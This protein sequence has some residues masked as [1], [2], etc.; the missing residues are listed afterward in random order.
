MPRGN[1]LLATIEAVHAAGL[2]AER[3]PG[4]LEA[5]THL[6]GGI[7]AT[8]E[9]FDRRAPALIEFHSYG[10]PP[11]NELAYLDH[12][13]AL[14]PRIPALINGKPGGLVTDYTVLD[15]R[16]MNGNPFYADFLMPVGYRYFIG[17]ILTVTNQFSSLFSVQRATR[18]GHVDRTEMMHM[19]CLLPHVRQAFDVTRRLRRASEAHGVF[20][21]ALD[22]LADGVALVRAD[23]AIVYANEALRAI[24]R[25][26]DGLRITK[27]TFEFAAPESRARFNAALTAIATLRANGALHDEATDLAVTRGS[28]LPP[29]LI[30]VRPLMGAPRNRGTDNR[31]VAIIFVRDPLSRNPAATQVLR[32]V[33]GL[34]EAEANLARALQ[35][36]TPIAAYVREHAV[37]INTV[38]T[39]LRRLKEKTGCKRMAELIRKL[40]DLQVPLRLD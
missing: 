19:R 31:A 27:G 7:A 26:N 32:E 37:S 11:A 1:D 8:L 33:F 39:H 22:W 5:I 6:C 10:L 14:N 34:T 24:F 9:V 21:H 12:Y 20:E 18:Q 17:G 40:N 13:A 16:G 4:A 28:G 3:W 38:Y 25:R 29:Y 35:A 30:S 2:D 15:E 23:G 36:G